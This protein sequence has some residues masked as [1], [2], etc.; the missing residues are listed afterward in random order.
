VSS[1][2]KAGNLPDFGD[3]YA[4]QTVRADSS[5]PVFTYVDDDQKTARYQLAVVIEYYQQA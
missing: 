5:A 3:G 4:V 2:Q 1:A